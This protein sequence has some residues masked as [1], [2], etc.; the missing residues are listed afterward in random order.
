[1]LTIQFIRDSREVILRGLKIKN[2]GQPELIDQIILKDDERRSLQV[3][4]NQLQSEMN[5]LSKEI[6]L[7][8]KS[9]QSE[10]AN[11]VKAQSTARK[12]ELEILEKEFQECSVLLNDLIVQIPNIPHPSVPPGKSEADNK[13]IREGGSFPNWMTMRCPTGNWVQNLT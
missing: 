11:Q 4:T 6:G 5:Q 8:F 10:K 7:L 13:L 2:F 12:K 3:K 9:G 1:M